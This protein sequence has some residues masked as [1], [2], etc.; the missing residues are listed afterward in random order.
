[1]A[2]RRAPATTTFEGVAFRYSNYDTPFWVRPNTQ[3]G[4]WHF[5]GDA[6]TQYLSSTAEGAWADLIRSEDLRSES[7]VA[8]V[9]MPLWQARVDQSYVVDY[10]SFELAERSGFAAEALIDDDQERCRAEG[11]R[12]RDL[13]YAG[14]I[15]PSAALPGATNLTLFGP[16]VSISWDSAP[17]LASAIPAAVVTR[18][19]P[20]QGLV[21]RVRFRG[22]THA[23][24][25]QFAAQ[26]SKSERKR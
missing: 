5:V 26:R 8:M 12:L 17:T 13:G 25:R 19:A 23:S 21:A 16:R 20:P 7:D 10:S 18:G 9:R 15:A 14:V 22:Q 1:M 4:R 24:F 6:P 11:K 2:R 3:P